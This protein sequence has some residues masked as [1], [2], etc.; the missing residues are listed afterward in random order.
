MHCEP[1]FIDEASISAAWAT[2]FCR[3]MDQG[4][5]GLTPLVISITDFDEQQLPN[6]N[7]AARRA[8]NRALAH[9]GKGLSIDTVAGTIFPHSFWHPGVPR[10]RLRLSSL[11]L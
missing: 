3:V 10:D 2:A 11:A 1:L 4:S 5:A 9:F 7:I 8:L 6:E